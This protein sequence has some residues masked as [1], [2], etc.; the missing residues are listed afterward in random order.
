MNRESF[1]DLWA[2]LVVKHLKVIKWLWAYHVW[3]QELQITHV[4]CPRLGPHLH[5]E[6]N[7]PNLILS[8]TRKIEANVFYLFD[9]CWFICSRNFDE[10]HIYKGAFNQFG[11][12]FQPLLP[13]EASGVSNLSLHESKLLHPSLLH[14]LLS[15]ANCFYIFQRN[16]YACRILKNERTCFISSTVFALNALS[17]SQTWWALLFANVCGT[18]FAPLAVCK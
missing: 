15:K 3:L 10:P 8:G 12:I 4:F 17:G 7:W 16:I 1:E 13:T 6:T 2:V 5:M 18:P 11:N 9:T 14:F